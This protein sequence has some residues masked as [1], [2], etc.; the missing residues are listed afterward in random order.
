[1]RLLTI[2]SENSGTEGNVTKS[3]SLQ[4]SEKSETQKVYA[5]LSFNSTSPKHNVEHPQRVYRDVFAAFRDAKDEFFE[6]GM[7]SD[8]LKRLSGQVRLYGITAIEAIASVILKNQAES[9]V[10]GEALRWL[11]DISHPDSY[12]LRLRLLEACLR[13]ESRWVRD[14]AL[15]GI[16]AINDQHSLPHLVSAMEVEP[17]SELRKDIRDVV[18]RLSSVS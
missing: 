9:R 14:G 16:D 17:I 7:E 15:L 10:I 13:H 4:R 12:F 3:R 1:M 11:G 5:R 2:R 8:F 18:E 6:F